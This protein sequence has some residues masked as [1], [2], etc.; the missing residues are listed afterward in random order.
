MNQWLLSLESVWFG[1]SNLACVSE[2]DQ[3]TH[4]YI[5]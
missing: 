1:A 5:F 4:F 2:L 3:L